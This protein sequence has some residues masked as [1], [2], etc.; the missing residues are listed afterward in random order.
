MQVQRLRQAINELHVAA[1]TEP[2]LLIPLHLDGQP[3]V[4]QL[5]CS[6]LALARQEQ[7][8]RLGGAGK[9]ALRLSNRELVQNTGRVLTCYTHAEVAT[10]HT[11]TREHKSYRVEVPPQFCVPASCAGPSLHL[12]GPDNSQPH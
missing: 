9:A 1:L 8:L 2:G 12:C 7:V 4:G 11:H 3:E 6:V 10:V 5:H